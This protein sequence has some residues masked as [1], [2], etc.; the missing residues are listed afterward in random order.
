MRVAGL[1]EPVDELLTLAARVQE[2]PASFLL[3]RHDPPDGSV[4][5][6]VVDRLAGVRG[7]LEFLIPAEHRRAA[8]V[9][10]GRRRDA[11]TGGVE[12]GDGLLRV[13]RR[14]QRG[15]GLELKERREE[16]AGLVPVPEVGF[17]HSAIEV[18]RGGQLLPRELVSGPGGLG[19]E[20]VEGLECV[21]PGF[22]LDLGLGLL[23]ELG[24]GLCRGCAGEEENRGE[25][26]TH[27]LHGVPPTPNVAD[28]RRPRLQ[29]FSL[30][31]SGF[32][33][34]RELLSSRSLG[35]VRSDAETARTTESG[36][37]RPSPHGVRSPRESKRARAAS[38]AARAAG[39][40]CSTSTP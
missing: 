35:D 36:D 9:R 32:G 39:S 5:P 25:N 8:V 37:R 34:R 2:R 10:V 20:H 38:S 22:A 15:I 12:G 17:T 33:R 7:Q 3:G 40:R 13:H 24:K 31:R 26:D 18:D 16:R 4:G 21:R 14:V 1:P 6:E 11:R 28:S 30:F 19:L 29:R 27:S 23:E